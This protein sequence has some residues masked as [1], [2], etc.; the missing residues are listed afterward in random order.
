MRAMRIDKLLSDMAIASR[1]EAS[2]AAKHGDITVNGE[3]VRDASAH[4][5]PAR[6]RVCYFGRAIEYR[7]YVYVM[8]NKP[9]G[10]VSATD[11]KAHPFVT[12]L[13]PDELRERDLF[14]VGRLDKDTV[15]LMLLT[16][17]GQS[18][19]RWL[20]PKRH[21]TKSYRFT[22]AEPLR[23]DCEEIFSRGAVLA[24]GYVCKSAELLADSERTSGIIT[25]T[26]GK[27]HQIKR[28][29]GSVNNKITSLERVTFG[30]I[31]LD[32]GLDRGKW[33][34]LTDTELEE[35]LKCAR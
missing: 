19:H 2:R 18:A 9:E 21:V 28:M 29:L 22:C 20:S 25:L 6:D 4:V 16:D 3:V 33:R 17:D 32:E 13:L 10:Y 11:D 27:Y 7:K 23:A 35:L 14:P 12:E 1:K 15:G 31:T 8:L 26:E 24:D 34:Y 30:P 5:D